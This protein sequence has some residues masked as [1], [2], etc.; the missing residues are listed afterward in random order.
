MARADPNT[1]WFLLDTTDPDYAADKALIQSYAP[2]GYSEVDAGFVANTEVVKTYMTPA[3][4]AAETDLVPG[5]QS[6]LDMMSY[7]HCQNPN[8]GVLDFWNN[9]GSE[10]RAKW[11][12]FMRPCTAIP[13]AC[14]D[15]TVAHWKSGGET[16]MYVAQTAAG[17]GNGSSY[18]NRAAVANAVHNTRGSASVNTNT[19]TIL[20][21]CGRM[22]RF[23][24]E[25]VNVNA[26]VGIWVK[27]GT[28]GTRTQVTSHPLDRAILFGARKLGAGVA[29]N[30][31]FGEPAS[32]VD[33]GGGVWS[34]TLDT[35]QTGIVATPQPELNI[36]L[37]D[38][39]GSG[40]GGS[41]GTI[42]PLTH[43]Y[44]YADMAA[45][46]DTFFNPIMRAGHR[47]TTRTYAAGDNII[48]KNHVF[49]CHTGHT[50]QAPPEPIAQIQSATLNKNSYWSQSTGKTDGYTYS[51]ATTYVLGSI[52]IVG[53]DFYVS[54]QNANLNNAPASSPLWWAVGTVRG[55][56]N[57]G[58][59]YTKGEAVYSGGAYYHAL[60]TNTNDVPPSANWSGVKRA[61]IHTA[62]GTD[63]KQNCYCSQTS[64]GG[65][66]LSTS[67]SHYFDLVG[68]DLY[69]NE[70][71]GSGADLAVDFGVYGCR[72][73]HFGV[74]FRTPT[75][76]VNQS[77]GSWTG[78]VVPV[79]ASRTFIGNEFF[80]GNQIVYDNNAHRL[81]AGLIS[82]DNYCHHLNYYD[83]YGGFNYSAADAHTW[84]TFG[85][86]VG[87]RIYNNRISNVGNQPIVFYCP[88]EDFTDP[89]T[90]GLGGT[91]GI[92]DGFGWPTHTLTSTTPGVLL[93][94]PLFR[95]A[96]VNFNW[97]DS[98]NT[99]NTNPFFNGTGMGI[100][101]NG[102][103]PLITH[104][105]QYEEIYIEDNYIEGAFNS[106]SIRNKWG[107]TVA[108][109]SKAV[110][111]RRNILR[112]A[113]LGINLFQVTTYDAGSFDA[114]GYFT[115][116]DIE[117][118]VI[119]DSGVALN[120]NFVN[121]L[122]P[123]R[124]IHYSDGNIIRNSAARFRKGS[125]GANT[126]VQWQGL[127]PA[128]DTYDPTS[129]VAA[130]VASS[131]VGTCTV[132][133]SPNP[134]ETLTVTFNDDDP[135]G[136]LGSTNP[137]TKVTIEGY[138]WTTPGADLDD[139]DTQTHDIGLGDLGDQL[140]A[141]VLYRVGANQ[142]IAVSS[143][144][145]VVA[146]GDVYAYTNEQLGET[147]PSNDVVALTQQ[148]RETGYPPAAGG[149]TTTH[150]P[151]RRHQR[152]P[153]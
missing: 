77:N 17:S 126:L 56:W 143:T 136:T 116:N 55:V 148:Q 108:N 93:A 113:Q 91:P 134:G 43:S 106:G 80:N 141:T 34:F 30:N 84:C 51:A 36:W 135:Q 28:S 94:M 46:N 95:D 115:D 150:R 15:R 16:I 147:E 44:T 61:Y 149:G 58:T 1:V 29:G 146:V 104:T 52:V 21:L 41:G 112:G 62:Q 4:I 142:K 50:D 123:D 144:V 121:T 87:W 133:G 99:L 85:G 26:S 76:V 79:E 38:A 72:M 138:F 97:L 145:T 140:V 22:S 37:T 132:T 6:V 64:T 40:T 117:A 81:T 139:F 49:Y 110:R 12:L 114:S 8:Y 122:N 101:C 74:G 70:F 125:S 2:V 137:S 130:I 128:G 3:E 67:N 47:N 100:S 48:Y 129:V 24:N 105:D 25:G 66:I 111:V 18:L 7:V 5:T 89:V 60:A 127:A 75:T 119:V 10:A 92:D 109:E 45:N 107:T 35:A 73:G 96:I 86:G 131:G 19:A 32:W 102:D 71:S 53:A 14:I 82:K 103:V 63:P 88:G 151:G 31:S 69:H 23:R 90:S 39:G 124:H 118:T 68:L 33:E 98:I 152:R 120:I 59:T 83:Y 153:R 65:I 11:G 13:T 9:S 54:I 27:N 57:A 78:G 42:R 20:F